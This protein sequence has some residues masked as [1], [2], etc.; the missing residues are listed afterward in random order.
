MSGEECETGQ[1]GS[2][3]SCEQTEHTPDAVWADSKE[4][5]KAGRE[6]IDR[7][8]NMI[9]HKVLVLSGKGGVGKSTVAVNI[10]FSLALEGKKVGLM[11]IDMHGPSISK[12][13]TVQTVPMAGSSGGIQPAIT[14]DGLKVMSIGYMLQDREDA[15]ANLSSP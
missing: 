6:A 12:L 1:G 4:R 15:N 14:S 9:A 10:A 2:C 5:E 8:M 13:V 3:D 11:D 7:R